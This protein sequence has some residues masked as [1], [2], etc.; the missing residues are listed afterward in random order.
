MIKKFIEFIK[1]NSENKTEKDFNSLGEWVEY[2][3]NLYK[4]DDE[5]LSNLKSI[6]NRNF[7]I[8]KEDD[9]TDIKSDIRLANAIN[10]LDD[11]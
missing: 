1:E 9:L 10:I 3:F 11:K 8:Y 2:L 6:V 5:K 7:N 4:N